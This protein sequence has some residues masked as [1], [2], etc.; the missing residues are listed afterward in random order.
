MSRNPSLLGSSFTCF[1]AQDKGG[2][3]KWDSNESL[4]NCVQRTNSDRI[5][6]GDVYVDQEVKVKNYVQHLSQNL[7][8]INDLNCIRNRSPTG[9]VHSFEIRC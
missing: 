1:S 3:L 4:R 7:V 2:S 9:S 6:V 8:V 5:G